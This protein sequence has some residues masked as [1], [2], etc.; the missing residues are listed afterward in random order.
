MSQVTTYKELAER[1]ARYAKI[2]S[3]TSI[4]SGTLAI[5]GGI[6]GLWQIRQ[7]RRSVTGSRP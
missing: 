1:Y 5:I 3:I 6:I 2:R 7:D 4:V